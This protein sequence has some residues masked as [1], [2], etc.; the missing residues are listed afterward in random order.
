MRVGYITDKR[1]WMLT[2]PVRMPSLE[3]HRIDFYL[4]L[5]KPLNIS[6][7]GR[8]VE[9][10]VS[11]QGKNEWRVLK[12]QTILK[13]G[14]KYVVLHPGGNWD[15]KRWP[16]EY[17]AQ[18][19]R[20]LGS[21]GICSVVCGTERERDL[22]EYLLRS[23][24]LNPVISFCGKTSVA[25]L[26]ALISESSLL[27]SN[28]SGP[29]HLAAGLQVPHVGLFGPTT[30][31]TTG[32]VSKGKQRLLQNKIGCVLPCFFQS[33]HHRICMENL[34]P[35]EVIKEIDEF[36]EQELCGEFLHEAH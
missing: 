23:S 25:S 10:A 30:T 13:E 36:I 11:Q 32:P 5:L 15:L 1:K 4:G 22:S 14:R 26:M 16:V 18:I 20:H 17:Y 12:S 2:H 7:H 29:L 21:K 24:G 19:I 35:L 9:L 33:C 34:R 27:I 3:T 8:E 6:P 28:D 31:E